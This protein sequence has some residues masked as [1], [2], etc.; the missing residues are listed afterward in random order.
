MLH[1][2]RERYCW[3]RDKRPREDLVASD[4]TFALSDKGIMLPSGREF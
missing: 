3:T 1:V 2:T 4:S